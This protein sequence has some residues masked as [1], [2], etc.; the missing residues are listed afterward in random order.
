MKIN[1]LH[2]SKPCKNLWACICMLLA[3]TLSAK[4]QQVTVD[5][6]IDSLQLLIGEQTKIKLEVSMDAQQK[7][8]LPQL[9]VRDTL[10]RGVEVVDIAKPDTQMLN[11][12]KRMLI[13]Q[14][15]YEHFIFVYA[16]HVNRAL[17]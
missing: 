16:L 17:I 8:Q 13:Q 14:I 4:A 1:I 7:L 10:V 9:M 15:V 2:I 3:I 5:A 12:G 6:S 11:D